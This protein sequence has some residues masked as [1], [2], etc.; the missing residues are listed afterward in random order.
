[1]VL[2]K[3]KYCQCDY[4]TPMRWSGSCWECGKSVYPPCK[5][6]KCKP[7]ESRPIPTKEALVK[8]VEVS[9]KYKSG[10]VG[11]QSWRDALIEACDDGLLI[12]RQSKRW[13]GYMLLGCSMNLCPHPSFME[14]LF[15]TLG[16]ATAWRKFDYWGAVYTV[17]ILKVESVERVRN[18]K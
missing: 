7:H 13:S 4:D 9:R 5:D 14:T 3:D 11:D 15:S 8:L 2:D 16:A 17:E 18:R 12:P 1:M 10:K 6:G